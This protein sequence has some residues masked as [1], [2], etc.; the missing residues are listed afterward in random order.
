MLL[1]ELLIFGLI[2]RASKVLRIS[3]GNV[4]G[5]MWISKINGSV[6]RMGSFSILPRQRLVGN[7]VWTLV[8]EGFSDSIMS[9]H[10]VLRASSRQC[11]RDY[12][13]LESN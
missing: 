9:S 6:V 11:C 13:D 8:S 7:V 5:I 1:Y 3:V 2:Y 4:V 10:R 12:L